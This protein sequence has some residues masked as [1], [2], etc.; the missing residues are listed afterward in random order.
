MLLLLL[1]LRFLDVFNPSQNGLRVGALQRRDAVVA[2]VEV[3]RPAVAGEVDV[4]VVLPLR[5]LL[6]LCGH[7]IRLRNN[8]KKTAASD[9]FEKR[10][11]K[12]Q[13]QKQRK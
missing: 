12:K 1:V 9:P 10:K 13:K 4:G 5:L 11:K 2:H 7:L 8:N 6:A 3:V